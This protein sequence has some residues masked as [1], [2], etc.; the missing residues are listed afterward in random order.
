MKFSDMREH[1][2]Q[3]LQNSLRSI[4]P[5]NLIKQQIRCVGNILFL[6]D[7][8]EIDLI[9]FNRIF[10]CG[11]GKGAAPMTRAMEE[12]LGDRLKGGNIIVKYGHIDKLNKIRLFEAGHP[13]PDKNTLLAT[14]QLLTDLEDLSEN[15]CVFVLI[16]GGGSALMEILPVEIT[17]DDL[18]QLSKVLLKCSA[19]IHEINCVRKHISK[20]KGGQLARYI[21]P[22][23]C[24][25]LALSDVIG[26]DLSVIAS[27]PTSPDNS[28]F[29]HALN[30][31]KKYEIEGEIPSSMLNH[32]HN[33]SSGKISET[34]K[35]GDKVFDG[36]HNLVIGN[37]RLALNTAREVAESLGYNTLVLTS[38]L[39]GEAKEIAQVLAA[40]I[41]EIQETDT[42]IKKPAC[43]L[44]GGEP[45][46]QIIGDGKGGRNQELCLSLALTDIKMPYLFTSCG[47]DGSDG[48]TDA[49]GA[50][51]SH[52]TLEKAESQG[53]SARDYLLNNDSY[54][55]FDPL[56]LLIKTGPTGTNVMDILF[57]L[58]PK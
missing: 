43:L 29:D 16:T 32:I 53:L 57:A 58:I 6:P 22:A 17:L 11:T 42:P 13:V 24:I 27:G 12:L 40:I 20:I 14:D 21:H 18:Q 15:D 52:E 2:Q 25:T 38:M 30:I 36:V 48:P 35:P 33:G 23:R 46:V 1:A 10:I 3:I 47:T 41:R 55:F 8:H 44:L 54:N 49:A 26:D 51:I 50:V 28:T 39:Q 7:G 5:Y 56:G 4:D 31:F 9:K 19:T 37:N 34:P 45:T